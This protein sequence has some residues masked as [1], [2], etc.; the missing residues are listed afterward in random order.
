MPLSHKNRFDYE[1]T[2]FFI[3]AVKFVAPTDQTFYS[4]S[5]LFYF[6]SMVFEHITRVSDIKSNNFSQ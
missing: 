4:D 1:Q 2:I 5:S 3:E 6:Y